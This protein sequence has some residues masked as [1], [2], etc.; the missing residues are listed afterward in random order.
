[1]LAIG[2]ALGIRAWINPLL[3]GLAVWLT[4]RLGQKVFG[5]AVGILAAFLTLTSP[6][7]LMITG[8]LLAHTW[9][10]FLTL[11]FSLGW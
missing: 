2:T 1:M 8:S 11:A 7:F 4:Y 9:S 6:F 3:A 10:V 5:A